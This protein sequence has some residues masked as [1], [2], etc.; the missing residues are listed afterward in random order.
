MKIR[1][2]L[3]AIIIFICSLGCVS[4]T[5]GENN[6]EKINV[7]EVVLGH[8]SDA[9]EWHI[10][11]WGNTHVTI[12]LLVIVKGETTGWHVFSSKRFHES[13]D[14]V[15]DGFYINVDDGK[16]LEK[17]SVGDVRPLDISITKNVVQLWIV[18]FLM[19]GIFLG[20]ARWYVKKQSSDEAPSGFVGFVEMFVMMIYDDVI[21]P[22]VGEKYYHFYAPY[23]LTAFFFIF[24]SNILGLIPFFPGGANLTGNIAITMFLAVCTFFAVNLFGNREYWKEIFWPNVPLWLKCPIPMMPIIEMFGILTKPFSLMVRLFANMMAGHAIVLSLTC[25]IFVTCQIG[26]GIGGTLSSISVIITI[27]MDALE[28]LVAFIQAYVFTMLSAVFI[29]LAHPEEHIVKQK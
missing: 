14:G 9:Y 27:F 23:L 13:S 6:K 3:S 8:M 4:L 11:T 19:L 5:A 20:C 2:I 21:K 15:Y 29:G 25:I 26:P 24:I 7:K 10:T 12:P 1:Y 16:I 18:V 17:T 22:N 28:V